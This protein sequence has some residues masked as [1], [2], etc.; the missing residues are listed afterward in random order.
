MWWFSY[1]FSRVCL[2]IKGV[3]LLT[4]S[5]NHT[6]HH[7]LMILGGDHIMMIDCLFERIDH[8]LSA[9]SLVRIAC[10]L[11][12][13]RLGDMMLLLWWSEGDARSPKIFVSLITLRTRC[14][15]DFSLLCVNA[16]AAGY[17]TVCMVAA[18][19]IVHLLERMQHFLSECHLMREYP[20][21]ERVSSCL[22]SSLYRSSGVST[23]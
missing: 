2:I 4:F 11:C 14:R 12:V 18:S 19:L 9:F 15:I 20:R 13:C 5:I 10:T 21:W 3:H 1:L 7:S 16:V 23:P 17:L 8:F 6:L 22:T